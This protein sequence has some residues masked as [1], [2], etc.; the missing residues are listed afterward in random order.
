[1]HIVSISLSLVAWREVEVAAV[2]NMV[3]TTA[4]LNARDGDEKAATEGAA[5]ASNKTLL[6]KHVPVRIV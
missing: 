1:M 3:P 2:G 4:R 6:R 5:K